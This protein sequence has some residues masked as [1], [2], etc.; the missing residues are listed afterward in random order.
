MVEKVGIVGVGKAGSKAARAVDIHDAFS[1]AFVSDVLDE[2]HGIVSR[3]YD[4]PGYASL[5]TALS[6]HPD[7]DLVLI[8]T[9]PQTHHELTITALNGGADIYVEKVMALKKD[10][11]KDILERA[12][13]LERNVYVRRNSLYTPAFRNLFEASEDIGDVKRVM[14]TNSIRPYEFYSDVKAD[15]LRE[16]PGGRISEHLPHALYVVRSILGEEP[17]DIDAHY[18]GRTLDVTLHC[19]SS[20][21]T[22]T[23][24]PPGRVSKT[25]RVVG[26]EGSV[27]LDEDTRQLIRLESSDVTPPK[28]RIGLDNAKRIASSLGQAVGLG[29]AHVWKHVRTLAGS[30]RGYYQHNTAYRQLDHIHRGRTGGFDGREALQN[31]C[32]FEAVWS[33]VGEL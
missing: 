23:Y 11:V 18:D 29:S 27:L 21:G 24:V 30:D 7:I 20:R 26:T 12:S 6:G 22:I 15:W 17:E 25:V 3:T 19:G 9:P 31:V 10:M 4:V 33:N 5:E 14:F 2:R 8:A 32:A 1:L 28:A 16:L 13:E